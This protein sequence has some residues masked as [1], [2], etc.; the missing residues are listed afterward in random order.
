MK[1]SELIQQF[2]WA[3]H[4][5]V[6]TFAKSFSK[7][8]W[9]DFT[10]SGLVELIAKDKLS[11]ELLLHLMEDICEVTNYSRVKKEIEAGKRTF[12][13]I[14]TDNIEYKMAEKN[15]PYN[16]QSLYPKFTGSINNIFSLYF[17]EEFCKELL[18]YCAFYQTFKSSINYLLSHKFDKKALNQLFSLVIPLKAIAYSYAVAIILFTPE[19]TKEDKKNMLQ[20]SFGQFLQMN[21]LC[22]IP[23]ASGDEVMDYIANTLTYEEFKDKKT[24]YSQKQ[25]FFK[26]FIG[27]RPFELLKQDTSALWSFYNYCKT[28]IS[29]SM[30]NKVDN[31]SS[32][33]FP[34]F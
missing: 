8:Q 33:L 4:P 29:L 21:Y 32:T 5:L 26:A 9:Q 15:L 27:I 22:N 16:P 2:P 13:K 3:D 28:F 34:G 20:R 23:N 6:R 18:H 11:E 10:I 7:E 24:S 17:N 31:E 1:L 19:M 25:G 12:I 14:V 30:E